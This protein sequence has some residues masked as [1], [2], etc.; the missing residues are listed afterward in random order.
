VIGVRIA[1]QTRSLVQP[2]KQALHTAAR[3]DADGVQID[4]RHELPPCE[5]SDTGVR[6]LRKMLD[7]LDLR[8][9]SVAFSSRRGYANP[10]D[11]ERRV[12]AT[13]DAMRMASRLG[14]GALVIAMGP[15]PEIDA[16]ERTT[17]LDAIG[18]LAN[19]AGRHGVNLAL[20]APSEAPAELASLLSRLPAGLV[21]VDLSPADI[22]RAGGDPLDF[23]RTLGAHVTHAY[24]NDAVR[25]LGGDAAIDVELG[26]G[27]ADPPALM[28]AL[29]EYEY[30][31][32]LT[33]ERRNSQRPVDDSANAVA[34]LR[35][36]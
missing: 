26:R 16:P 35:S 23:V 15:L 32:W 28:A 14:A 5:L 21:G 9:G 27:S 10:S 29:E 1:V 13:I 30:R 19:S 24:A 18:N 33:V 36:L 20:Q 4:A 8:V 12:Q 3:I 2:F 7:D 11:L 6:Q 34:Y 22:I 17:L 25:G 31:G